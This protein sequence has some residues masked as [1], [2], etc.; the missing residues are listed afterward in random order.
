[1]MREM[2]LGSDIAAFALSA[3]IIRQ[4]NVTMDTDVLYLDTTAPPTCT[5]STCMP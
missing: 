5:A 2:A 3:D 1:M 4:S